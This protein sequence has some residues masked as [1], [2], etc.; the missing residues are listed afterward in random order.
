MP[1]FLA[2][3]SLTVGQAGLLIL[4]VVIAL[5][6]IGTLILSGYALVMRSINQRREQRLAALSERWLE[7]VLAAVSD[8]SRVPEVQKLVDEGDAIRFLD[9]IIEYARRVRGAEKRVLRDLARPFLPHVLDRMEARGTEM[10]A[11]A[12]QVL[13]T[14]G[15]PQY[16]KQVVAA[17]DDP[18]ALVAM[19]AARALARE[20]TPQYAPAVLARLERFGEWN[21]MFLASMLA[22]MGPEVSAELRAGYA[23]ESIAPGTRAVMAEALLRQGDFLAGD[24]AARVVRSDQHI[25]LLASSFR[26]LAA[27]GRPEHVDAVRPHCRS[28]DPVVRSQAL[29]AMGPLGDPGDVPVLLEAMDDESPWPALYA[30][31]GVRDAGGRQTLES[32]VAEGDQRASL[33]RQVLREVGGE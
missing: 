10:R 28:D 3:L 17:L 23:D 32:M 29:R 7:P 12:I 22:A 13:G 20:E 27:I 2:R 21:R 11:W 9:F 8:P 19:I 24:I 15:L 26:L 5:L 33:A 14:L 16:E 30:A 1:D 4:L 31:R 25:D 6:F 18:S